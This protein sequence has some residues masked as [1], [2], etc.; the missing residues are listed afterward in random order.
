MPGLHRADAHQPAV[1]E[2]N[3]DAHAAG[4]DEEKIVGRIA[5]QQEVVVLADLLPLEVLEQNG[6]VGLPRMEVVQD[7]RQVAGLGA[8][9]GNFALENFILAPLDAEVAV[10]ENT[11]LPGTFVKQSG[12]LRKLF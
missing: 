11:E 5:L 10:A 3:D 1:V 7:L 4:L 8:R 9:L 12:M 6:R 2:L